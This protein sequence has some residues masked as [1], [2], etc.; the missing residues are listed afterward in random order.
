MSWRDEHGRR[1]EVNDL[2]RHAVGRDDDLPH[3]R[4]EIR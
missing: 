3:S 2:D 1:T 4:Q